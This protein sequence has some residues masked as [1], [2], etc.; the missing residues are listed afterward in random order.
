MQQIHRLSRREIKTILHHTGN[1]CI[2]LAAA[3]LI[4]ILVTFIYNE[5]KYIAS[6]LYS[7]IISAVIGFLLV[8]LFRVE[9]KMTL[10]SAMIFSTIIWLVACALVHYPTIFLESYPTLTPIL[11]LCLG[12]PLLVS[13]CIPM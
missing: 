6:F 10:K 3:M 2:L 11:R 4:P 12:S 1:V 5:P 8:K 13:A 9:M 7:A